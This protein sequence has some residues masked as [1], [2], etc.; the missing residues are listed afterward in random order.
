MK[1]Q[2]Y[3]EHDLIRP[4]HHPPPQYLTSQQHQHQQQH[5]HQQQQHYYQNTNGHGNGYPIQGTHHPTTLLQPQL[6]ESQNLNH[7]GGVNLL[8]DFFDRTETSEYIELQESRKI[9]EVSRSSL[10]KSLLLLFV[11]LF[12]RCYIIVSEILRT[13]ILI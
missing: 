7:R 8:N 10:I 4:E 9:I 13:L 2:Q 3:P 1:Q 11:V 5:H 6:I 12:L